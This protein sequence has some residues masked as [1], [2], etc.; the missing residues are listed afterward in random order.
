MRRFRAIDS[1]SGTA[2]SLVSPKFVY[3]AQNRDSTASPDFKEG[4]SGEHS[5]P[6]S[7][8]EAC[9]CFARLILLVVRYRNFGDA[10]LEPVH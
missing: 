1:I 8:S 6:L 4:A 9:P 10:T 2:P 5:A 7:E 3:I